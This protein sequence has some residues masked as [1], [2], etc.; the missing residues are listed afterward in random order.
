MS[1]IMKKLLTILLLCAFALPASAMT[2]SSAVSGM[3]IVVNHAPDEESM[4]DD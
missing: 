4:I 1:E 2:M 3:D